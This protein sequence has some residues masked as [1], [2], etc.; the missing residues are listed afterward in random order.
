MLTASERNL[1]GGQNPPCHPAP[2]PP[3]PSFNLNAG[4]RAQIQVDSAKAMILYFD[5]IRE[6]LLSVVRNHYTSVPPLIDS[7]LSPA[8]FILSKQDLDAIG[9]NNNYGVGLFLG[10]NPNGSIHNIASSLKPY[11]LGADTMPY[12]WTGVPSQLRQY[13]PPIKKEPILNNAGTIIGYKPGVFRMN[14]LD[15]FFRY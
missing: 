7:F 5:T 13:F 8:H 2:F 15:S 1:Q 3:L 4:L 10:C 14:D 6:H 9:L 11:A 12:K